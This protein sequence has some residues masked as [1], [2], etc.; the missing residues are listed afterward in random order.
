MY[1][2]LGVAEEIASSELVKKKKETTK[3][4]ALN[5]HKLRRGHAESTHRRSRQR[6]ANETAFVNFG[7]RKNF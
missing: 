7:L 3:K 6:S 1:F 5:A 2:V 4:T